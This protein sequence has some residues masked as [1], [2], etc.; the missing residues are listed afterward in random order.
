MAHPY[1]R[2]QHPNSPL[3]RGTATTIGPAAA[4]AP[5]QLLRT[6]RF[7]AGQPGGPSAAAGYRD[8]GQRCVLSGKRCIREVFAV[9]RRG[10]HL[11]AVNM[12]GAARKTAWYCF[13][14][15]R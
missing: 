11:A 1:P 15:A 8:P 14:P 6:L 4:K 3:S 13:G 2:W 5:C 12:L 7:D 10:I 9:Q